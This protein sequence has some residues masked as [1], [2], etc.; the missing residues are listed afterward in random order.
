MLFVPHKIQ[1]SQNGL[2]NIFDKAGDFL[3]N[4]AGVLSTIPVV[5]DFALIG[6]GISQNNVDRNRLAEQEAIHRQQQEQEAIKRNVEVKSSFFSENKEIIIAT[7]VGLTIITVV[8]I[9]T[10]KDKTTKSKSKQSKR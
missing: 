3:R 5:G 8:F 1:K 9:A 2:G 7:G 6:A 10:K 4:N